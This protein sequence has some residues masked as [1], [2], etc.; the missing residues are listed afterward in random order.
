MWV[1]DELG[2][3]YSAVRDSKDSSVMWVRARDMESAERY[4]DIV[5]E[6]RLSEDADAETSEVLQWKNRDYAFRVKSTPKEWAD[7]MYFMAQEIQATNFKDEVAANTGYGKIVGALSRVWNV[8][9]TY[10]E[11]N[12]H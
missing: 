11:D 2:G 1:F 6:Y 3:F 8:M 4:R 9:Y 12:K 10:Q 7:Y 5:N